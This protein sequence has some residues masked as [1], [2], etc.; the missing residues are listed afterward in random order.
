MMLEWD[1]GDKYCVSVF[2]EA[3]NVVRANKRVMV[4]S[5]YVVKRDIF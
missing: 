2:E 3:I 1:Q 4:T 5:L